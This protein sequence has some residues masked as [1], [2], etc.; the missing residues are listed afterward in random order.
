MQSVE[1]FEFLG[2]LG[3]LGGS[4]YVFDFP[5]VPCVLRGERLTHV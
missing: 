3:V 2:G 1:V 4:N 5:R